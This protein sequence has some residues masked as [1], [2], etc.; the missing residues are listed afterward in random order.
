ME[1]WVEGVLKHRLYNEVLISLGEQPSISKS[2]N[3]AVAEKF[4]DCISD[5]LLDLRALYLPLSMDLP[6]AFREYLRAGLR[7][8]PC[9]DLGVKSRWFGRDQA[10]CAA[11]DF[12]PDRIYAIQLHQ[13]PRCDMVH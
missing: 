8:D 12:L 9:D 1:Y 11:T 6:T 13:V 4:F 10:L 3:Q 5:Y 7:A 2:G